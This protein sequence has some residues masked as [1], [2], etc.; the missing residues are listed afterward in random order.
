LR[1]ILMFCLPCRI[2]QKEGNYQ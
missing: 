1:K 2:C